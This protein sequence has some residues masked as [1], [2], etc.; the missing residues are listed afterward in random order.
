MQTAVDLHGELLVQQALLSELWAHLLEALVALRVLD[1]TLLREPRPLS[2]V[3][4]PLT[5]SR[6]EALDCWVLSV[7]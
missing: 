4:T 1:S 2:A 6:L 3:L 5:L 7:Q